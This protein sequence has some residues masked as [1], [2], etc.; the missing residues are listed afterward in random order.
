MARVSYLLDT[1]IVIVS[2]PLARKP[3]PGVLEGIRLHSRELAIA[4]I[5]WQELLYG[6]LL[7][8]EGKRRHQIEDY[9]LYR[10]RPTLPILGFDAAA[11]RWQA[12]QRVRLRG[13]GQT[14][15][16]P[17]SQIAA[18]AAVNECVLVTC[19]VADFEVFQAAGLTI[20]NWFDDRGNPADRPPGNE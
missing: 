4:T 14:P 5:T 20:E 6:M 9:L 7:L 3:N 2:E 13:I 12:E 18:I 15:A 8:P 11:A 10:V 17:D 19:N 1:N 16:Y